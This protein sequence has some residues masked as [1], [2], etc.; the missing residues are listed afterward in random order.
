L[1]RF[2]KLV[3]LKP[4]VIKSAVPQILGVTV[5]MAFDDMVYV[6]TLKK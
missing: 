5:Q 1:N 2:S 3:Q 4:Q 6:A